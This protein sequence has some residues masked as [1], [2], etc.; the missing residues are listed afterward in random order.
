[1]TLPGFSHLILVRDHF[2]VFRNSDT[3]QQHLL[4]PSN[5]DEL[6]K[7]KTIADFAMFFFKVVVFFSKQAGMS[8]SQQEEGRKNYTAFVAVAT[9]AIR[10]R[11]NK[12]TD[13]RRRRKSAIIIMTTSGDDDNVQI[14]TSSKELSA[15]PFMV[16]VSQATLWKGRSIDRSVLQWAATRGDGQMGTGVTEAMRSILDR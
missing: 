11:R 7:N 16:C 4:P 6:R 12:R 14:S 1:V 13:R 3:L 15:A 9:A 10:M 2:L 5:S 8:K